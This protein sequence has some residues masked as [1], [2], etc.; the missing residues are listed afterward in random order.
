LA[1]LDQVLDAV[2][3]LPVE[4]QEILLQIIKKRL[5]ENMR[6]EIASDAKISLAEFQ[7]GKLQLKTATEAI[8]ELREYLN[9]PNIAIVS[10]LF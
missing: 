8:Q 5:T 10:Q 2:M 4:Q 9:N 6:N 7:A 3:E 1:N